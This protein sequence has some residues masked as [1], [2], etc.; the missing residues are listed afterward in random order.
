MPEQNCH[1]AD[2][3]LNFLDENGCIFV[4]QII[5]FWFQESN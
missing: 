5:E 4:H 3:M 2:E 1:F